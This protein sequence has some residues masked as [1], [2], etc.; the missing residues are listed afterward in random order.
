[1]SRNQAQVVEARHWQGCAIVSR[2]ALQQLHSS[3]RW[4][5]ADGMAVKQTNDR[6]KNFKLLWYCTSC[7]ELTTKNCSQ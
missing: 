5:C 3:T 6:D 1:M 4:P 7:L 2:V